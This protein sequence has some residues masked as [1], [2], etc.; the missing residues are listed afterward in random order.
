MIT[1]RPFSRRWATV[2]MLEPEVVE[3]MRTWPHSGF[4]VDKS[5]FLPS[6]DAAGIERLIQYMTRCPFSLS[7]LVKVSDTGH[8]IYQSEKQDCRAFPD[9][10]GDGMQAGVP[11]NFQILE[12]H[13]SDCR[14]LGA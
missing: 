9:P 7:R 3:N 14:L 2:S 6:G 11:R 1:I 13:G 8:V 4:S 12:H 10:K 5:V